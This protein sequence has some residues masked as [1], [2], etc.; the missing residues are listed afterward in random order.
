MM[1]TNIPQPVGRRSIYIALEQV[2]F[3][4]SED[5]LP[6]IRE[7]WKE[8]MSIQHMSKYFKR[9]PLEVFLIVLD[10][11]EHGYLVKREGGVYGF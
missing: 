3:I 4:W 7:A 11:I 10:Q 9:K 1:I 6:R 2:D 8:G 5:D